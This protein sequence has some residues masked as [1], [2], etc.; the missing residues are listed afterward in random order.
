M[1]LAH[2][3]ERNLQNV[4]AATMIAKVGT[5]G[6]L[7][8]TV[9]LDHLAAIEITVE[10]ILV[11]R[12]NVNVAWFCAAFTTL[13]TFMHAFFL[14]WGPLPVRRLN[15]LTMLSQ[16]NCIIVQGFKQQMT[17]N[18]ELVLDPDGIGEG[19]GVLASPSLGEFETSHRGVW[20]QTVRLN[21]DTM[22]GLCG[23]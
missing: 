2:T 19:F 20:D 5:E 8:S 18:L 23:T 21:L 6:N 15:L 4:D 16:G 17:V 9:T 22:D 7:H 10:L 11:I 12:T 13:L 3:T 1:F 14:C